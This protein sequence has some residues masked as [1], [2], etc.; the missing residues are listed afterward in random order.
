[1]TKKVEEVFRVFEWSCITGM[2]AAMWLGKA[3][4]IDKK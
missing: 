3:L 2:M 4:D 1:M